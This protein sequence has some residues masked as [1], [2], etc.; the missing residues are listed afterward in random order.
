[1]A[2]KDKKSEKE[3][4]PSSAED[5][6]EGPKVEKRKATSSRKA[7]VKKA[8]DQPVVEEKME[9]SNS[10]SRKEIVIDVKA[11]DP[12][13]EE[14]KE[15]KKA[16]PKKKRLL[17]KNQQRKRPPR[18]RHRSRNKV[19]RRLPYG[20]QCDLFRRW[21]ACY[22]PHI[23]VGTCHAYLIRYFYLAVHLHCAGSAGIS[24]R[25]VQRQQQR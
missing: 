2:E 15:E 5:K 3:T 25:F 24:D 16:E 8:A 9:N 1:M 6:V 18:S 17:S 19:P 21:D 7:G 4:I 10:E 12:Q 13:P 23:F 11:K 22:G 14:K 20:P